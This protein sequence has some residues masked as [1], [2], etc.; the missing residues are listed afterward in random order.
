MPDKQPQSPMMG[1]AIETAQ[2]GVPDRAAERRTRHGAGSVRR[3][4][5]CVRRM[6]RRIDAVALALIVAAVFVWITD[7]PVHALFLGSVGLI[8]AWATFRQRSPAEPAPQ[9]EATVE[10]T[11]NEPSAAHLC[12]QR[13]YTRT[14]GRS[15]APRLSGPIL[16]LVRVLRPRGG[17]GYRFGWRF[18]GAA[19]TSRLPWSPSSRSRCGLLPRDRSFSALLLAGHHSSGDSRNLDP[20]AHLGA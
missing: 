17:C 15:R 13:Q 1:E 16:N 6:A 19:Q 2:S 14:A 9:T 12:P 7:K 5:G 8:L 18:R 10:K 3:L 4:A 20:H 11:S